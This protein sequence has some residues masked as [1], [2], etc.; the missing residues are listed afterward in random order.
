M[1]QPVIPSLATNCL[2]GT[3]FEFFSMEA[4][5]EEAKEVCKDA[6][7]T[8]ARISNEEEHEAVT[9]LLLN[10]LNQTDAWIGKHFRHYQL[11]LVD[12]V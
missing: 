7:T 1:S 9:N 5:F 8:L 4:R 11:T 2:N 10:S 6:G 12:V 3:Q